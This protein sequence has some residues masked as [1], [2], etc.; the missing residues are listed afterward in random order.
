MSYL[1]FSLLCSSH[2]LTHSVAMGKHAITALQW[3]CIAIRHKTPPSSSLLTN[4]A[5]FLTATASS[6]KLWC[7]SVKILSSLWSGGESVVKETTATLLDTTPSPPL[8]LLLCVLSEFCRNRSMCQQL[9][10]DKKVC[11]HMWS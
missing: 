6:T 7:K 4:Q 10:E 9:W 5:V 1:H 3:S 8:L 2:V 11:V